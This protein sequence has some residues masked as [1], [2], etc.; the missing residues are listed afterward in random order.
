LLL[1]LVG[2]GLLLLITCANVAN[3]FLSRGAARERDR[4]VRVAL[5]A[6]R[7]RLMRETLAES[8]VVSVLGGAVG[9]AL[10][11]GLLAGL[12][13]LAP[14]H[15]PRLD[16]VALDGLSVAFA[17]AA[18]LL[19]ATITG[20]IP[21][22]RSARADLLPSL[23]D[24]A[25]A[26]RG[27]RTL[28]THRALLVAESTLAVMLLIGAA[29]MGR[30]FVNLMQ[31]DTGYDASNVLTARIYLPGAARGEANTNALV[32][33]LLPRLRALPGATAAGAASMAPFARSTYV[34][35]FQMPLP[36]Q[37]PVTVRTQQYLV[38]PGYV[39]SLKL[40]LQ[41]GRRL[42]ETDMA[43]E[44]SPVLVNDQFVRMFL[45]TVD[46]VGLR[47]EGQVGTAEIVGVVATVLKD[48][49]EQQPQPEMYML[50]G[51]KATIRR[52]VYLVMRT[53]G[54]PMSY[55]ESVRSIVTE[56]RRDAAVEGLEPLSSQLAMSVAQ[57]R[58]AATVLIS[59]AGIA[60]LLAAVG[61]YGVLSYS[62]ARRQREIGVRRALGATHGQLVRMIVQEGVTVTGIGLALGVLLAAAATR[63]LQS[64]LVGVTPLDPWSFAVAAIALLLVA[65][66]ASAL[67]ARRA[68]GIDPVT[69]LRAE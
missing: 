21:A 8:L 1:L 61:L 59:L 24:G 37:P 2:V 7:A 39:E 60:L 35:A 58:F 69:A 30:S 65:V 48:S 63:F 57:P 23:R 67:P 28:A 50:A 41:A 19:A 27:P 68:L 13:A 15:F 12:P 42:Y 34:S 51:G 29:L 3:L 53:T 18:S 33:A 14:A 43:S 20:I 36:G 54:D 6:A 26:S 10:A 5:G 11:S 56:L 45:G 4:S 16:A 38:T 62:V 66:I 44:V 52:E 25:G 32:S 31:T 49:L 46:P 64:L 9:I 55:A 17:I 22:A 40:R 47:F